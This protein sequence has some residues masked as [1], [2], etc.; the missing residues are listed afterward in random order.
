M[1]ET[2]VSLTKIIVMLL[3]ANEKEIE[4][5]EVLFRNGFKV[6]I[7]GKSPTDL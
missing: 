6:S 5:L 7:W 3:Q 2:E 1:A 4:H